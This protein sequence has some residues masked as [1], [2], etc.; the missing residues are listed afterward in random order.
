M[1]FLTST[2]DFTYEAVIKAPQQKVVSFIQKPDS[3]PRQSPLFVSLTPDASATEQNWF[4]ITERVPIAGP[5]E[6]KT[7]FRARLVPVSNGLD[8]DVEASLGVKLK[9]H[10][11]VEKKGENESVLKEF[12]TM[13]ASS[14]LI[15]FTFPTMAD[16]HK[17]VIDGVA[18]KAAQGGLD[19]LD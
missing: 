11:T 18:A 4:I 14:L 6:T 1:G 16:A 7:T 2:R 12:T 5:I 9:A 19:A 10:Y 17:A 8:S 3:L 15:G 13:E